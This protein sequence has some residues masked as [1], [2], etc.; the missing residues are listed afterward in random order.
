MPLTKTLINKA[1]PRLKPYKIYDFKG[2]YVLI[3]PNGGKYFR[4]NYRTPEGRV[5]TLALGVFPDISLEEAREK[6]NEARNLLKQGIDPSEYK[7]QFKEGKSDKK[8]TFETIAR[9]WYVTRLSYWSNKK[10]SEIVIARLERNVFPW[11][12]SRQ[13]KE[14]TAPELLQVLK[15]IEERGATETAHRVRSVCG[16]IFRYGIATGRCERDPAADLRGAL[17]PVRFKHMAALTNPID[18]GGLLRAIEEYRGGFVTK[19]A[20]KLAALLF[21]RP[22]ELRHAEWKEIDIDR[23]EWRIPAEKMKMRREHIVPL[24]PQAVRILR[25]LYPLT[26][27][28]KYVFPSPRSPQRCMSENAVLAALRR[29]GYEKTEMTGHGFRSMASTLLHEKGWPSEIIELQLA[30]I[31]KNKVR[32]AYNHA[33]HI[34]KR[35]RMME[36][37]ADYLD[38][39]K[40]DKSKLNKEKSNPWQ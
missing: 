14:I 2:L 20:L 3:K 33:K 22:G 38:K 30:H 39:L 15:R 40:E 36:F 12:G 1:E 23:T 29:M 24:A 7:R 32:E 6:I 34:S 17:T 18:V 25:E 27:S 28:G 35:R 31:D 5:K 11:L 4:Y 37:W 10:Q 26:C 19:C 9:E 16:Q 13:I 8:N 21:V